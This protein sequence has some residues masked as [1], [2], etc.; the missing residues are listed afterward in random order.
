MDQLKI[1]EMTI[2]E[3]YEADHD[4]LDELFKTFQNWKRKDYPRA[5]EAFVAFKFGLQRHIVW[6]E[7]VLFP[8]FEEKVGMTFGPTQ[9]MRTEHREIATH[10]EAIHK[11]VQVAD[12]DSDRDEANLLSVLGLHNEKEESILYPAIDRM[13]NEEEKAAVFERMK[14]IPEGRYLTCCEHS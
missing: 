4:R 2:R 12:P 9:V 11:K 6:E 10:L 5:K 1:N 14:N 13:V 7:E 3:Y 8:I